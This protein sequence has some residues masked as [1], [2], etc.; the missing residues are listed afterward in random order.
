MPNIRVVVAHNL[1]Q[2]EAL[3]RVKAFVTQMKTQYGNMASS[4]Q[5]SWEGYI[6]TFTGSGSGMSASG[7]VTV[8][9]ADVTLELTVPAIAMFMKG[10]IES[11]AREQLTRALA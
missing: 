5:E 6:G 2:D 10:T 9:P 11:G 8:N 3:T 4:F 7:T 1:P